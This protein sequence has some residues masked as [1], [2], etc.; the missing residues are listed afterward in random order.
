[1]KQLILFGDHFV[2]FAYPRLV[3]K[4]SLFENSSTKNQKPAIQTF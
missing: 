4:V 2:F 3:Q 1:M